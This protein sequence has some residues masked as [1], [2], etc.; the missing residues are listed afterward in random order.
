MIAD[1]NAIKKINRAFEHN[2]PGPINL[3]FIGTT[4]IST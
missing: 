2:W 1:L 3:L 4:E